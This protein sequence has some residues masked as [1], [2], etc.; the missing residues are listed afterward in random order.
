M[1]YKS[2]EQEITIEIAISTYNRPK[3]LQSW[4]DENYVPL[5][6]LGI[7]LSIYDSS[8]NN[9]TER[10]IKSFNTSTSLGEIRYVKKESSI[11]LDEKVLQSIL[12]SSSKYVWPL[13]DS[14]SIDFKDIKNKV[15]PFLER[16]YDFACLFGNTYLNNDGETYSKPIDFFSDCFWHA[17]WLGG[18]IFKRDIFSPLY[19]EMIYKK[20]IEKYYR[21]DGFSYLGIFFELISNETVKASFS[22]VRCDGKIGKNKVP[23]WLK[24]YMEV[25]CDNLIYFVDSIPDYYNSAKNKVL[26]E[27]WKVLDLDGVWCCRARLSGGL[28]KE[29]FEY[30]EK[31]GY[32]NRVV[33]DAST[34]KKIAT[35]PTPLVRVYYLFYRIQ[36]KLERILK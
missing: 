26:K 5:R 23:G 9:E 25:W 31:K 11:R 17:T 36:R 8:T 3:I 19:D 29:N 33:D 6:E 16:N 20:M 1:D 34:I 10:L 14:V 32:I 4:L 27:T 22:I 35:L 21:N 13:S 15:F 7:S 24:R 12:D 18:I 2:M 30:Y 28:N